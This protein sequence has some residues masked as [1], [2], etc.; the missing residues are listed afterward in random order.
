MGKVIYNIRI[1]LILFYLND[2][3]LISFR[4]LAEI[5]KAGVGFVSISVA[6][7]LQFT[8]LRSFLEIY[9]V[10]N[11]MGNGKKKY[12]PKRMEKLKCFID[13]S[14]K[15]EKAK[16]SWFLRHMNLNFFVR[17]YLIYALLIGL[18]VMSYF[19]I[20]ASCF[21]TLMYCFTMIWTSL[22]SQAFRT[23]LD[24]LGNIGCEISIAVANLLLI[25]LKFFG[26]S[27]NRSLALIWAIIVGFL[28]E[29][30][31]LLFKFIFGIIDLHS[32]QKIGRVEDIKKKERSE[33]KEE[34]D[35]END[36]NRA[37]LRKANRMRKAIPKRKQ[38]RSKRGK[39]KNVKGKE[40][41]KNVKGKN[42]RSIGGWLR[43]RRRKFGE[44]KPLTL[45]KNKRRRY[46]W[47]K[48]AEERKK[49]EN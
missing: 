11:L 21:L 22:R 28:I 18:Q 17:F 32:K 34:E 12:I 9:H 46:L 48:N 7:Y 23:I 45:G 37:G 47:N 29:L 14:L 16:K 15:F 36:S 31:F 38:R 4:T 13:S 2:F 6:V 41:K 35:D 20:F 43:S 10:A 3:C 40:K 27:M 8:V 26:P 1:N 19:Q 25:A 5:N 42:S 24:V 44:K 33:I 30:L 39:E 49:L